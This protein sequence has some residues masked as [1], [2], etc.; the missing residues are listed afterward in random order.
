MFQIDAASRSIV[1]VCLEPG[2][3]WRVLAFDHLAVLAAL[4]RHEKSAHPG[5]YAARSAAN[6]ARWR[7]VG[8]HA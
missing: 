3:P 7:R 2:C 8:S 6:S 5:V 4:A 1:G